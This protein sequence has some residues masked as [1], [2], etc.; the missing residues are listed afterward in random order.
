MPAQQLP[1]DAPAKAAA[2]RYARTLTRDAGEHAASLSAWDQ[3]YEQL[4]AGRYEGCLEEFHIGPVQIFREQ[5]NQA[6][7][8]GGRPRANT[9]SVALTLATQVAGWYCGH[10]IGEGRV[11]ALSSDREFD[12]VAGAGM[13][14]V[15]VCVDTAELARRAAILH[16]RELPLNLPGPS[17][18]SRSTMHRDALALLVD[19]AMSLVRDRPA[20]LADGALRNRLA[21]SL[22]DAVLESIA[23]DCIESGLLPG[24]AARRQIV[25]TAREYM[26]S[27]ADEPISV[28]DL[29]VATGASRRALQ[30]AFENVVQLSPVTYLRVMRLNRVRSELQARHGDTVGDV[31]ARWGFWHPSRFAAEYRELFGELPSVTRMRFASMPPEPMRRH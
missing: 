31:A 10:E 24:A 13:A 7:L 6:V 3:H 15:G 18:I 16:G 25:A 30:Y 2:I 1:P 19:S 14:L 28:P 9:I 26:R 21:E 22:T 20:T 4:S 29:C 8:Q 23:P 17:L 27:H 12:L 5:S 11:F